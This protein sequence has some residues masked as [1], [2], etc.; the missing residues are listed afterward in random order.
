M[1]SGFKKRK[2]Q[3]DKSLGEIFKSARLKREVSL[4]EAEVSCKVRSKYLQAL[5]EGDWQNL[6]SLVYVRGFVLAY[7]NFLEL[8]KKEIENIFWQEYSF[9]GKQKNSDITYK[10]LLPDKKVLITP[11]LIGYAI[12]SMFL[13][14]MFG[15]IAY[16]II[17]F[18]GSPNL[19]LVTPNN[20]SVI[21]AD[22]VEVRGITDNDT[23]LTINNEM[24]PVTTDGRFEINLK[25]QKGINVVRIKAMNRAKKETSEI[26]TVEYKPKTAK[27]DETIINQ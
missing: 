8:D 6:P 21:E 7:A 25:L 23:Y 9:V 11:K 26:I 13:V 14:G 10:K 2:I 20:N 19:R 12:F 16:Q 24:V 17:N 18:A 22:S 1:V 15:Y 4:D 27:I 5:E 3:T